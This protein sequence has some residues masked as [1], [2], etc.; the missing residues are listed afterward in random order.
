VD[1]WVEGWVAGLRGWVSK[2]VEGWLANLVEGLGWL[3]GSPPACHGKL[4]GFNSRH[5]LELINGRR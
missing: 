4:S 5:S 3:S 2:L 1:G